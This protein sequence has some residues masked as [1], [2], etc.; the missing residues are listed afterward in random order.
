M[1]D[2]ILMAL[3]LP[4]LPPLGLPCCRLLHTHTHNTH[5]LTHSLTHS[6]TH[7]LTHMYPGTR[8]SLHFVFTF[9]LSIF[10][11]CIFCLFMVYHDL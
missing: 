11:R 8:R 9:Y 6:H 2:I 10:Y 3:V 7:T 5:S 1:F 4:C